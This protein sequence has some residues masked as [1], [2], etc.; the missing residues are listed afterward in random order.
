MLLSSGNEF[1]GSSAGFADG[2]VDL[3]G[4]VAFDAAHDLVFGFAFGQAASEVVA[5]GPMAAH[6]HHQDDVQSPVGVA[7]ASPVATVPDRFAA[8]GFQWADSAE[9]GG[10]GVAADPVAVVAEGGQ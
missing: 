8:G 7:I 5:G 9:F 3:A 4:D 10:S 2:V 6:A 1:V